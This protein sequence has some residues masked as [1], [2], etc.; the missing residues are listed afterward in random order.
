MK[1]SIRKRWQQFMIKWR[2]KSKIKI[3]SSSGEKLLNEKKPGNKYSPLLV[4]DSWRWDYMHLFFL[5]FLNFLSL[6]SPYYFS[7]GKTHAT[8]FKINKRCVISLLKMTN[9]KILVLKWSLR[10]STEPRLDLVLHQVEKP[11]PTI[12]FLGGTT[13]KF[14]QRGT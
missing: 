3:L 12:F 4:I 7:T 11:F 8:L 14:T 5:L 10:G 1:L 6:I 13:S 9:S 2:K